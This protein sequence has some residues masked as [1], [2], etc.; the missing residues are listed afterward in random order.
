M[1]DLYRGFGIS[2]KTI[3]NSNGGFWMCNKSFIKQASSTAFLFKD[4]QNKY[5]LNLPE[6][7]VV[8]VL[9]HLFSKDYTN[10]FHKKYLDYWASEWIGSY[11]DV[12]PNGDPW[13]FEEYMTGKRKIVNPAIVHAMR[14]KQALID[15]SSAISQTYD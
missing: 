5:G 7:V 3:Y 1:V 14:S 4:Y 6:E 13:I 8:S 10:R 11:K 2:Q 12:L 15:C 9:S